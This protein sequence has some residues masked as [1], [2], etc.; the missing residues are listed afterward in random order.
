M[1]TVKNLRGTAVDGIATASLNSMANNANVLGATVSLT[2]GEP[3]YR[4]VEA[5][6]LVTF[7][8]NPTANTSFVAWLLREIDGTNFEDGG[9]SVTPTRNPDLIFTVRAVTTAQRLF[10][11]CDMPP[12]DFKVLL[13][14]DGTGQA[15]AASGNTLRLRP[16][17]ES[18]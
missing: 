13:R 14:N 4:Q 10:S 5:E 2:A 15:I 12:G 17:T 7:G 1:P 9:A 18:F 3:G 8:T 6:L 11:V 16:V